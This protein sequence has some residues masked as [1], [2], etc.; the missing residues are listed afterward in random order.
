MVDRA[1]ELAGDGAALELAIGTGRV[2]IALHGRGVE[3]TGIEL[4]PHMAAQLRA[5]PAADGIAVRM[6]DMARPESAPRS[7]SCTSSPTRS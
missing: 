2:A 7:G 1:A 6:G 3:V 4:S 5:K